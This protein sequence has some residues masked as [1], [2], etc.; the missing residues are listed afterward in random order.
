M[1]DA[2]PPGR[3]SALALK[4]IGRRAAV[5]IPNSHYTEASVARVHPTASVRVVHGA[6]DLK[7]FDPA[8]ID[9]AAARALLGLEPSAFVLAVVAQITPWKGHDDAIRTVG[10]L[11]RRGLEARLLIVGSPKFVSG[12]TRYDNRAYARLLGRP[13]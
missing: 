12:A 6:V 1:H 2:L 5:V 8:G 13:I 9:P 11:K 7:R 4:A 3:T 10:L